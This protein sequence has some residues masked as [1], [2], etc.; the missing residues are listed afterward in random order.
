MLGGL[1]KG[2]L[3]ACYSQVNFT[4]QKGTSVSTGALFVQLLLYA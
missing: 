2:T 4:Y 3:P 1:R